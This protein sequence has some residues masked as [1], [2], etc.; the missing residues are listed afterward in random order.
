[1]DAWIQPAIEG[2]QTAIREAEEQQQA[3][4]AFQD[5]VRKLEDRTYALREQVQTTNP[6]T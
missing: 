3:R 4:Q 2:L 1:M 6:L 5:A